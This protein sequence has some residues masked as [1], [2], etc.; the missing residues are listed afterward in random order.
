MSDY[1]WV[2]PVIQG[3]ASMMGE[4]AAGD[5]TAQQRAMLQQIYDELRNVPLPELER[6][7]AEQLGPTAMSGVHSD[8]EQRGQQMKVMSELQDLFEHGGFNIED[9]AALSE[10]LNRANVQG[11]AQRHA[12]AGEFAQ[13]GQ[14]GSGARLALGNMDAQG[15][16]NRAN[17]SGLDVA[18][19]GE[20]RR[21][22][23][24]GH[25][26]DLAGNIRHDDFGEEA[27]RARAQDA[28]DQWNAGAREKANQ[29]NAGLNQQQFGNRVTKVTGQQGAGN[30]LASFYGNEAQGTRNQFANY[31]RAAAE[32]SKGLGSSSGS[33]QDDYTPPPLVQAEGSSEDEWNKWNGS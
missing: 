10:A 26:A 33:S 17:Q 5:L 25:Y 13:R 30:N 4:K 9:R 31:G 24:L 11:S 2:G 15:A 16:A 1:S 20:R 3:A 12:L 8:P 28:A 27:A 21:M 14:L 29:Y 7:Q 23:A 6:I 32:A 18:A 22:E 19:Q